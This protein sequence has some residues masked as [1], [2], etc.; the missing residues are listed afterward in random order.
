MQVAVMAIIAVPTLVNDMFL[1]S[2][3]VRSSFSN[4]AT[5]FLP[6][7]ARPSRAQKKCWP[8]MS[9]DINVQVKSSSTTR[10]A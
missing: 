10:H 9:I 5:F 6:F 4:Y 7:L 8:E 1:D 2:I 3:V